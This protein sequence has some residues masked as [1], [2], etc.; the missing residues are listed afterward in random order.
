MVV[1]Q[2]MYN[3]L[4]R[5]KSLKSNKDGST[6]TAFA[7]TL[8]VLIGAMAIAV[9]AGYWFKSKSDVQLYADMAA[10]AGALELVDANE[11]TARFA[12]M[13]DALNNG[14][15]WDKGA[16][17]VN[18]PPESG[19]FTDVD[20]VEVILTQTGTQYFSQIFSD[21][22]VSYQVRAVAAI[23]PG[24]G[25]ACIMALDTSTNAGSVDLGGGTILNMP[26]CT[27]ESNSP[28]T[29]SISFSN[30]VT[31]NVDCVTSV[32]TIVGSATMECDAAVPNSDPSDDPY[33]SIAAPDISA[34]PCST[35]VTVGATIQ[36]T[37]GQRYC[38][39]ITVRNR[40][41]F[42]GDGPVYFDNANINIRRNAFIS[43]P[44]T[45]IVLMNDSAI[46]GLN[47]S[48]TFDISAP[49]TGTYAGFVVYSD[50]ATQ[51]AGNW[52]TMNGSSTSS[53]DGIMYYPNQNLNFGGNSASAGACTIIVA[54][55]IALGGTSEL[56]SS[57]CEDT[58]GI[59]VPGAG[60]SDRVF[61]VE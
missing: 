48:A 43:G 52:T 1:G 53:F 47:G 27:I 23:M 40:L 42:I 3:V 34:L 31:A 36:V 5:V 57:G 35:P 25:N 46:Q 59:D 7:I 20:A 10:Y 41:E 29:N 11:R 28:A 45:T 58:Y 13:L 60:A 37:A 14:Y 44:S 9:E 4:N 21:R 61:I 32:G 55:R 19:D 49:T 18:I 17:D 24:D 38:S 16:I 56:D 12:A 51:P 8:P 6:L 39:Q 30:N 2:Q 33:A 50:P 15:E 54:S 26:G 22:G